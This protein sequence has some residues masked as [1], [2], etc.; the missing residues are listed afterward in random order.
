[1]QMIE[2]ARQRKFNMIITRE[3]SRFARNTVDTLQYTRLL[4][5]YGVEVFLST[6]TSR[7]LTATAN[8]GLR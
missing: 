3:V 7:P 8:C 1:M 5:E 4:K 6:I 2:D